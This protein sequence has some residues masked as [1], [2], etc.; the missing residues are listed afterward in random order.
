MKGNIKKKLAVIFCALI[1]AVCMCTALFLQTAD[2]AML[3][4]ADAEG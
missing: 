3:P 2:R 1:A 4:T